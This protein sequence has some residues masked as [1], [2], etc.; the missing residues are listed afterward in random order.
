MPDSGDNSTP[1]SVAIVGRPNVG[2]SAL[3]NCLAKQRIAIVDPAS[4]VTRD[5]VS[6]LVE[7]DGHVVEFCD[8]GGMGSPDDLVI[9]VEAQIDMALRRADLILFVVDVQ[10]GLMPGDALVAEKLRGMNERVILVA[11]KADHPKHED[12]AA[13]FHRLGLG[14][15]LCTSALHGRGRDALM[16]EV[17]KAA[18]SA[19]A[20]PPPPELHLAIVGRRNVGKSTLI[21]TLAQEDRVIVSETPGATRD[22]VD[23]RFEMD[24]K[25][26]VAIDTAGVKRRTQLQNSVEFYSFTRTDAAIRRADVVL[27]LLDATA[28]ISRM[29]LRIA[30]RIEELGKPCAL[31]VNKWDL[32]EG[33]S[34][35][36]YFAYLESRLPVLSYAPVC[37]VSA[38][39]NLRVRDTVKLAQDLYRQSNARLST[40]ELNDL[41]RKAQERKRPD[42]ARNVQPKIMY[43][44]QLGGSPPT[45]LL[46]ASHP[47]LISDQYTRYLVGFLR[48][49]MGGLETPIRIFYR[50]R[51][52]AEE[53]E[54][55]PGNA[56]EGKPTPPSKGGKPKDRHSKPPASKPPANL[57]RPPARRRAKAVR[58]GP[59]K[60]TPRKGPGG[61]GKGRRP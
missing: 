12:Q 43:G 37:F 52:K 2:K 24:G 61:R 29:D 53:G 32:A 5:R 35:E 55:P 10:A 7:A 33:V 1:P 27:L 36:D 57:K 28:K 6:A 3:F 14:A 31:V 4:G 8:T 38:K 41:L 47:H 48:E 13:E 21:N 51:H 30:H 18:P 17:L 40:P 19:T 15:P 56:A 16:R 49:A 42:R 60:R 39:E 23:V 46:F 58:S 44:T 25:A 59:A 34:T 11:N 26:F 20:K 45:F 54:A 50:S 9:E 22:S